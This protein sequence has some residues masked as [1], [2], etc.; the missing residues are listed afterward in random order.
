[1][2][3]RGRPSV[4]DWAPPV[5]AFGDPSKAR[6]VTLGLNPSDREFVD[7]RDRELD[8]PQRRFPTLRSLGLEGWHQATDAHM[9][10]IAEACRSYFERNPND[11]WFRHLDFLIK[12]T[13]TSF[14]QTEGHAAHLDLVP[15]AT[16]P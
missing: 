8:G 13:G 5:P 4:I 9:E 6:V 3:G 10:A 7:R 12:E 2:Q 15:Y 16:R 14:Y 11:T 1:M